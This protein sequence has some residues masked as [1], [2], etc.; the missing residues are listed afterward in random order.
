MISFIIAISGA[1]PRRS[2]N[3]HETLWALEDQDCLDR[4][5]VIVEQVTDDIECW[6]YMESIPWFRYMAIYDPVFC[7]SWCHNVGAKIAKGDILAFINAD[8][9]C[10]ENYADEIKKQFTGNFSSGWNESMHF[11]ELGTL[12]YYVH[13]EPMPGWEGELGAKRCAPNKGA[14]W[15][16]CALF[17]PDFFWH[18][19][20]FNENYQE[21]GAEDQEIHR[22]AMAID[23]TDSQLDYTLYHLYHTERQKNYEHKA[24]IFNSTAP[25]PKQVCKRLVDA[26]LGNPEKRQLISIEGLETEDITCYE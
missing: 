10:R 17:T 15:G 13:R 23:K 12:H 18:I 14:G 4:E 7:L 16:M 11:G 9:V 22:R 24:E 1:S 25:Y 3:F 26:N 2:N 19:G 20:G 21:W 6:D 8:I 5:I